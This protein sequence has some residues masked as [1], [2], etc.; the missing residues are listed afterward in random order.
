MNRILLQPLSLVAAV[1]CI[2]FSNAARAAETVHLTLTM[3][4]IV[5]QGESSQLSLDRANTIECLSLESEFFRP[6]GSRD[7]VHRPVKIVKRIDKSTPLLARSL[8]AEETGTAVFRFFR[9]N[10]TGDGTT[11]QFF[12]I[13]LGG[14]RIASDR[15]LI[16]STITQATATSPPMEE[17]TFTYTT[18]KLTYTSNGAEAELR[19]R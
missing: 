5:I 11:E 7:A 14:V 10:P 3:N 4:D 17:V 12:T 2:M 8:D 9:P 19:V 1:I 13:T 6:A 16:P 18:I 15:I